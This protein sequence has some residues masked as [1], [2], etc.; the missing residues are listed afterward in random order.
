LLADPAKA[1][2]VRQKV[3]AGIGL[4]Q[5]TQARSGSA[6]ISGELIH[7]YRRLG[8]NLLEGYGMTEDFC[9]SHR[10]TEKESEVGYVGVAYPSVQ[11]RI[12]EDGE[13]LVKSPGQLAGYYKRPDLDAEAFTADGF[14]HTGD[15]GEYTE[16][17]LLKVT[18]RKKELF[19]TAKG[20]FVAPA[21]IEN[22]LN[23]HPMVELS[24]V[25]GVGQTAAYAMVVI[26]ETLRPRLQEPALREQVQAELT[27]LLHRV[28]EGLAKHEQLQMLVVARE[29]WS[30]D[31]GCLTPTMKIK[32]SRIEAGVA[33]RLDGWYATPAAVVWA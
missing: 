1:P 8:L 10:C 9:V 32:R 28:N 27:E 33:D 13:I 12:A 21:P 14:F 15:L 26:D 29:P 5:C 25:S 22:L 19:K 6:P 18:G 31:N 23:T 4:D 30:I 3:L 20:K 7:W 11:A 17:G 24:M 2:F 16:R